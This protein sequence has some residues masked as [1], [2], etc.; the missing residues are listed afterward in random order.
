MNKRIKEIAQQVAAMETDTTLV[1]YDSE[2]ERFAELI[3]KEVFAT[4]N[5]IKA[6]YL[7]KQLATTDFSEKNIFSEGRAA[8][9]H[10][11]AELQRQFGVELADA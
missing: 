7:R 10:L 4:T 3:I 6:D 5:A 1:M 9:S 11:E 8:L 2:I